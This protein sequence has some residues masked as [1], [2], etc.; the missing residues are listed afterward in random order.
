MFSIIITIKES[1]GL[2]KHTSCECK[3]D[4][5]K[6]NSYQWWNNDKCRFE[7]KKRPVCEKDYTW[8]PT[9]C[10]CKYDK[11]L[12]S[13]IDDSVIMCDEVIESYNEETKTVARKFNE[14]KAI[15]KIQNFYILL[16]FLLITI[17]LL[18]GVSIYCYLI[19]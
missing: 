1:K 5:R 13:I 3:L 17:E 6:C 7:C 18:I 9:T 12:A 8:T 4:G 14:K 16:V 15:W 19:K 11:Y 10:S 2:T